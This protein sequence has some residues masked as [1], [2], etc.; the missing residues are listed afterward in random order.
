MEIKKLNLGAFESYSADKDNKTRS[1]LLKV[2]G[3][4]SLLVANQGVSTLAEG[5]RPK[6]ISP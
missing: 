4:L 1:L 6:S 3:L 5:R 2:F